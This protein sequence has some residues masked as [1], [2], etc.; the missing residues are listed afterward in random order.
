MIKTLR[1]LVDEHLNPNVEIWEI[2]GSRL[3]TPQASAIEERIV[4]FLEEVTGQA[5]TSESGVL[6]GVNVVV[7]HTALLDGSFST[8]TCEHRSNEEL[9]QEAALSHA[10]E[11]EK[12]AYLDE[13]RS[14]T[15]GRSGTLIRGPR[16]MLLIALGLGLEVP[17]K[18]FQ[19][20]GLRGTTLESLLADV[21]LELEYRASSFAATVGDRALR[22]RVGKYQPEIA[23]ALGLGDEQG[24]A[25]FSDWK[26]G[27][28][29][30]SRTE[31][32]AAH[33]QLQAKLSSIGVPFHEGLSKPDDG[34]PKRTSLLAALDID[35]AIELGRAFDQRAIVVRNRRS[36]ELLW[37]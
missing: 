7:T 10:S 32:G 16:L 26:R 30:S 24:W 36:S 21:S 17:Q 3:R 25:C 15:S 35:K 33:E 18:F 13:Y 37:L 5:A 29:G 4:R 14:I 9:L 31:N 28:N 27:S 6:L 11:D 12:K 8:L 2:K 1:G 34:G 20:H 19:I 23:R 22:I